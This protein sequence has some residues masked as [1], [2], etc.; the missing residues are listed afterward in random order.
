MKI[1]IVSSL[2]GVGGGGSGVMAQHLA[3]GLCALGHSVSVVSMGTTRNISVA[4]ENGIK[5]YRFLPIN[6]YPLDEKDHHPAWQKVIWQIVDIHNFHAAHILRQILLKESPDVIHINKM[7]GFSGAVWPVAANLF[8]GRVMQ[9]CHDYESMSPDGVM[10]G[11]I[12]KMAIE[13]KW[14]VRGYQLIRSRLSS[15][16]TLVSA[17]SK[18]TLERIIG[19]GLFPSAKPIVI[20]NTHGWNNDELQRIHSKRCAAP[21]TEVR[22]LYLGR[23]ESEKGIGW[24]CEVFSD[25]CA[26]HLSIHLDIAGSGTLDKSLREKYRNLE[27]IH[28]RGMVEGRLKEELLCKA[29][30]VIVPSLVEE[31]FGLVTIEAFAF[32]KPVIASKIGGLPELVIPEETGW[33]VEPRDPNSLKRA[34]ELVIKITPALLSKMAAHCKELSRK[35]TTDKIINEYELSYFQLIG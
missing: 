21:D 9:T 24:L 33:L 2:Y 23:L 28:F 25:L 26:S 12:G 32:G 35:F 10:R 8:P 6:L 7:R 3:R 1:M 29:T 14:P 22:F 17:P 5:M 19:S 15:A 16:V 13:R 4:E 31:S 20:P 27:R 18:F 34:L 30:A 11:R